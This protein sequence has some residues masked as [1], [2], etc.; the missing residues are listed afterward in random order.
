MIKVNLKYQEERKV[1]KLKFINPISKNLTAK[2]TK[3]SRIG[4][5]SLKFNSSLDL[6]NVISYFEKYI[7]ISVIPASSRE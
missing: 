2:I 5:V 1:Q 6:N 3:I 4:I 7:S